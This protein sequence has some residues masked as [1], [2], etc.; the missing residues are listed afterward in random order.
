MAGLEESRAVPCRRRGRAFIRES[1]MMRTKRIL[2]GFVIGLAIG[3]C[4]APVLARPSDEGS[5]A[6]KFSLPQQWDAEFFEPLGHAVKMLDMHYVE[7]VDPE[8]L[9][10]GA[11]QGVLS[12]LDDYSVYFP[13]DVL[14]EFM[15]DTKGEFGGL[16]IQ[17]QFLVVEKILRVEQPIPGTPAFRAGVLA[18][19]IITTIR[20]EST[21]EVIETSGFDDVHDAVRILR[22]KPGTK[23]TITVL[24]TGTATRQREDIT[25]ER[26]IIKV[27]GVRGA[28]IVD[29]EWKIGYLYVASFHEATVRDFEAAFEELQRQGVRALIL[30]LRFNG[31]GLLSSAV[32][33]SDRLLSSGVIVSTRGRAEPEIVFRARPGDVLKGIPLVVLVNEFSAS[34]SEIVAAAVKQNAC[35]I[36]IGQHTFG[37]GSV[38][39]VLDIPEMRS[40][41]KLTTARYYT[42]DGACIEKEGVKPHIAI[43]LDDDEIRGL[44]LKLSE[45]AGFPP[46]PKEEPSPEG[47]A[48][49]GAGEAGEEQDEAFHDVQLERAVDVLKGVLLQRRGL[50]EAEAAAR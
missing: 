14:N 2:G 49:E 18:H 10:T 26:A 34:A 29:P 45:E 7:E 23:V 22:G 20:E 9:L 1:L 39:K 40:A 32:E 19:D 27:P 25:I 5:I 11:F 4:L 28:R 48:P 17:I 24:H 43:P 12:K 42:P 31:G 3:L 15:A 33:L 46:K 41:I 44:M 16:G 50:R 47:D 36:L 30:D 6:R 37:K 8:T 38:Q 13:E 21:G 35:G